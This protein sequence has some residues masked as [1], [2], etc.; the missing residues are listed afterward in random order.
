MAEMENTAVPPFTTSPDTPFE[1]VRYVLMGSTVKASTAMS[2]TLPT[3]SMASTPNECSEPA[4]LEE[5]NE[6]VGNTWLVVAVVP[7]VVPAST[8]APSSTWYLKKE[9]ASSVEYEKVPLVEVGSSVSPQ[10]P[11]VANDV[12]GLE[13]STVQ[14]KVLY[15]S[16]L[17]GLPYMSAAITVK[18]LEPSGRSFIFTNSWEV[19]S[20]SAPFTLYPKVHPVFL[21]YVSTVQQYVAGWVSSLPARSVPSTSRQWVPGFWSVRVRG[22]VVV[23]QPVSWL[24]SSLYLNVKAVFSAAMT[25]FSFLS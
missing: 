15:A 2:P 14:E 6:P 24:P 19:V 7:A 25:T 11:V 4:H 16:S 23:V 21:L 8:M 22:E 18:V 1:R 3:A 5:G 9:P 17:V 20:I 10:V 13:V 12:W